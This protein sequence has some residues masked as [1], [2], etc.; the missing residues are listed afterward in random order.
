VTLVAE[1]FIF[2]SSSNLSSAS[3]DPDEQTLTIEF[4]SGGSY[5]YSNVPPE[6]YRGL[7]L[8]SSAGQYF[9]RQIKGRYSFEQS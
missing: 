9:H 1:T 4:Q 6:T 2:R 7:T 5:T 3:Y 8:A